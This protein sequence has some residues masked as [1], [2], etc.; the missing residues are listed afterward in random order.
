M[1]T[2]KI[3]YVNKFV[4]TKSTTDVKLEASFIIFGI[5]FN[6]EFFL[7]YLVEYSRK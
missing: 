3:M 1:L 7:E 4:L 5:E 2:L 6:T